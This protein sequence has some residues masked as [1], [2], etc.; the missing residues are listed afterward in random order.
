M[1]MNVTCPACGHKWRVPERAL[2][3]Q[4]KCPACS[5]LFQCGSVSPPSLTPRPVAAEDPPAVRAMPQAR[6]VQVQPDQS[7]HY[8]CPR[9]TKPLESP[10]H[11]A[12]QKASCPDCG[13]RLQVPQSSNPPPQAPVNKTVVATEEPPATA[14]FVPVSGLGPEPAAAVKQEPNRP[15]VAVPPPATPAP[16]RRESCLECGAGLTH[17][18]RVLTCP[19]CGSLFCSARCFREHRYH[20][21]PL[22]RR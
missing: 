9:C 10:I 6:P 4:V 16:A 17:Q 15:V 1:F 8:Q 22:S 3:Q 18:A 11:M 12:G 7:I 20:A 5:K 19:D 14:A 21:H 2:G 13:Q